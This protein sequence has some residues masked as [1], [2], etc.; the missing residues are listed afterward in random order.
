LTALFPLEMPMNIEK[1]GHEEVHLMGESATDPMEPPG[2]A[3]AALLLLAGLARCVVAPS[4]TAHS[5]PSN[6][7]F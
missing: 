5:S 2:S 4:L 1:F 3:M 7:R 6:C